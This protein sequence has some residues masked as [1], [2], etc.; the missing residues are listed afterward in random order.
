MLVSSQVSVKSHQMMFLFSFGFTEEND[1]T[2]IDT[3][4]FAQK[5][6]IKSFAM[7]QPG[8]YGWDINSQHFCWVN[9]W[10]TL[11]VHP[12]KIGYFFNPNLTEHLACSS[13][14]VGVGAN[15]K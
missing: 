3:L 11:K 6:R 15:N 9:F 4:S 14:A 13:S 1:W 7:T 5:G 8:Q 10:G 2:K 12:A